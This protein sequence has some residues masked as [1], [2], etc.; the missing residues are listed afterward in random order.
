MDVSSLFK[1]YYRENIVQPPTRIEKREFAFSLF[2]AEGMFRH[3]SFKTPD[4][5]NNYIRK[6]TPQHA[7]YSTAYYTYPSAPDMDEKVWEGAD[8]VFDIDV[9]HIDTP[10]KPMHD[11]WKCKSCGAEGWGFVLKCPSCGSDMIDR[12][13]WVCDQCISVAREE[14]LKLI[15]I[16]EEDFGLTREEMLVAFSG[17]RGFH[18]HIEDKTVLDLEQEARREIADYVRGLGIDPELF[19]AKTGKLYRYKY[20]PE[21]PGWRGRIAKLLSLRAHLD[22]TLQAEQLKKLVL[23]C[24]E[25]ARANIDE[26]VTMDV[27]RLIRLPGTLHGKTGLKVVEMK[28]PD[29]EALDALEILRKAIVFPEDPVKIEMNKW[30]RKILTHTLEGN[31]KVREVP[32]YLAVY[33]LLNSKDAKLVKV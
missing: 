19:M 10:C 33:L 5:L 15:E 27:K 28:V 20:G 30:P 26:K 9:D 12:Q 18:L 11:T 1:A 13:T 4:E 21:D 25:E 22:T 2:N 29:L 31:Q 6:N 16:L 32:L 23:E 8:L 3:I 24:V 17:H 14:M 7:Y